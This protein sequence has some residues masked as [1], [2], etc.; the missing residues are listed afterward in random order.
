MTLSYTKC[1][2]EG[3]P[4][5]LQEGRPRILQEGRPSILQE[6]RPRILQEGRPS[7][8]QGNLLVSCGRCFSICLNFTEPPIP[9]YMSTFFPSSLISL[10]MKT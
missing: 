7:I 8:L 3:R 10:K 9:L 5:I 6:G 1:L 2:Q 4:L